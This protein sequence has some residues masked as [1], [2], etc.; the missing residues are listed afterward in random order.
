MRQRKAI[1]KCAEPWCRVASVP[2]D[3]YCVH[4]VEDLTGIRKK[5]VLTWVQS[6]FVCS[7]ESYHEMTQDQHDNLI[8]RYKLRCPACRGMSVTLSRVDHVVS[9]AA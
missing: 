1:E 2:E 3:V 7:R 6:C 4:H 5:Q 9:R 8:A